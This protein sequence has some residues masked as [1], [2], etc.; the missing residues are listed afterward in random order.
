MSQRRKDRCAVA[1]RNPPRLRL[2]LF[3]DSSLLRRASTRRM[4][5]I[6]ERSDDYPV[7]VVGLIGFVLQVFKAT[8]FSE[9]AFVHEQAL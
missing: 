4:L 9:L 5:S 7:P 1:G 6:I 3:D 2:F 8:E